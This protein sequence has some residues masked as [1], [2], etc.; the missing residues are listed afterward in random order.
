M[1]ILFQKKP[2]I[3][4]NSF[5]EHENPLHD[6][7]LKKWQ[8]LTRE[9]GQLSID[10]YQTKKNI[11]VKSTIAGVKEEDIDIALNNDMLTIKG[12]RKREE[13][14]PIINYLYEECFWGKFSRTII[15][16]VDVLASKVGA[17]LEDGILTIVLPIDKQSKHRTIKVKK[18]KKK[19]SGIY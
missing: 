1:Q 8:E 12:E 13:K 5:V 4:E 19:G 16:P 9:E 6:E 11:I 10:V 14:E 15:L 17:H 2:S 18:I 7:P 3:L